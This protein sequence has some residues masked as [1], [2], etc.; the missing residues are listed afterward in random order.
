MALA[1]AV[2]VAVDLSAPAFLGLEAGSVDLEPHT[3]GLQLLAFDPEWD[4]AA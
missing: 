3:A 1:V 2:I 4:D